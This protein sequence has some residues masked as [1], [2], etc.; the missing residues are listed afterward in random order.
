VVFSR[1]FAGHA[2][3][4]DA[5]QA[6]GFG[7]KVVSHSFPLESLQGGLPRTME[8]ISHLG[9]IGRRHLGCFVSDRNGLE[10]NN[11]ERVLPLSRGCSPSGK[12]SQRFGRG[13]DRIEMA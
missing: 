13:K 8:R 3:L 5:N 7:F 11:V 1:S 12:T 2:F 4:A 6:F 10:W 9:R